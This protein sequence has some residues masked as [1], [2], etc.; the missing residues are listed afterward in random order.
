M[1]LETTPTV[2]TWRDKRRKGGRVDPEEQGVA[3]EADGQGG[4]GGNDASTTCETAL[5]EREGRQEEQE[6]HSG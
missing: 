3:A 2:K 4:R 1:D 6:V 5:K